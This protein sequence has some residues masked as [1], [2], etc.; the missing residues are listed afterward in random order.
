MA[1][2]N[3]NQLDM[4]VRIFDSF[5]EQ[6]MVV[7]TDQFDIVYSFFKDV[8]STEYIA[9]NFTAVLFRIAFETKIDVLALLGEIKGTSNNKLQMNQI[10]AYYLNSFKSKTSLYGIGIIPQPVVPVAR[11][12]VQ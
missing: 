10:M 4:T 11:N 7:P 2:Y 6:D 12:I 9:A 3:R 1:Q 8:C 5:Y